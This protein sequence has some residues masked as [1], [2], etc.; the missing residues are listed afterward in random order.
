MAGGADYQ[1]LIPIGPLGPN[2]DQFRRSIRGL[3]PLNGTPLYTAVHDSVEAMRQ[4]FDPERINGVV[5]LT[6]GRNEDPNNQD[7]PG[8]L[9]YLDSELNVRVFA[10]AYGADADLGTLTRIAQAST[11][12][13][14][15][16]S[17]PTTI[18]KVFVSV[19]S[20]F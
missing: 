6:D 4:Q 1:E 2:L 7:L 19:I 12:A 20:N 5:L 9:R 8:L 17:D 15:D 14:Y 10:I 16:A 18:S 3:V 13:V 11:G